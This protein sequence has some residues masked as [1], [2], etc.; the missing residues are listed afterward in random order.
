[1]FASPWKDALIV[2]VIVLLFF[3]PKRLP[4]L[5]RS[6]GES[7]KEFKGGI[8][9]ATDSDEKK[10]EI[11]TTAPESPSSTSTSATTEHTNA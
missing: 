5:S 1:M 7:I 10:S 11:S 6:I 8:A 4:A 3:G 2:L 9:Q